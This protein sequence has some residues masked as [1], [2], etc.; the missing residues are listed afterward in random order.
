MSIEGQGHFLT[1][2]KCQLHLK[3]K[4]GFSQIPLGHFK[5][6]FVFKLSGTGKFK[7]CLHDDGHMTKTAA[8]PIY[9]KKNIQNSSSSLVARFQ[10]NLVCSI[11]DSNPIIVCIIDDPGLILTYFMARSNF[12]I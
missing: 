3:I 5:P 12:V 6:N 1:L 11:G 2:A 4:T 8:L 10:R 7:I 9:G